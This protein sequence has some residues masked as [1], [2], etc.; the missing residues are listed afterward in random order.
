[1]KKRFFCQKKEFKHL[2]AKFN[3]DKTL[4]LQKIKCIIMNR[5]LVT[6]L[7]SAFSLL[8][9]AQSIEVSGVQNGV[10]DVDTV[11]VVGDVTVTDSLVIMMGTKVVF[12]GEYGMNI[13]NAQFKAFG[14]EFKPDSSTERWSGIKV[15]NSLLELRD[16]FFFDSNADSVARDGGALRLINSEAV[17]SGCWFEGCHAYATGGAVFAI[18]S[19]VEMTLC[20]VVGNT[21]SNDE[22]DV[23]TYGAGVFFAGSNAR[24]D[25]VRFQNNVCAAGCGGG[26]CIDSSSLVVSHCVFENNYATNGGGISCIRADDRP[27]SVDN[28]LID[29]NTVAH[30]GGAM[31]VA[32]CYNVHID[33]VTMCHNVCQG[34]GGGAMQFHLAS[35]AIINNTIIWGNGWDD[36]KSLGG[37]QI[38]LWDIY[39]A[40][41]FHNCVLQGGVEAVHHGENITVYEN[42]LDEDPLFADGSY[43]LTEQSPC[44]NAGDSDIAP[45]DVTL[46]LDGLNRFSGSSIDMGAYEFQEGESLKDIMETGLSVNPVFAHNSLTHVKVNSD[47]PCKL[48]VIIKDIMG[49]T[50]WQKELDVDG[51]ETVAIDKIIAPQVLVV[52]AI[53]DGRSTTVKCFQG[54]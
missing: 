37:D 1:L 14:I 5:L 50:L 26:V 35:K 51:E 21:C 39:S 29:Y 49:Q 45:Y 9:T 2:F 6:I 32:Q 20:D 7:L 11:K 10:W 4:S 33:N 36:E 18:K 19:D 13:R 17:I 22:V 44:R 47:R 12:Y 38:W 42:M 25:R 31:H 27:I 46:D 41:E 52:T 15:N 28:V 48:N 53:G 40:P 16:C 30:Y 24:L 8:L 34:G 43:R 23:Y 3:F 54:R